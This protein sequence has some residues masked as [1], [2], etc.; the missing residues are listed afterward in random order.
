MQS[1]ASSLPI[2][3]LYLHELSFHLGDVLHQQSNLVVRGGV[4]EI[5][6]FL[7]VVLAAFDLSLSGGNS[8]TLF[9][10]HLYLFFLQSDLMLQSFFKQFDFLIGANPKFL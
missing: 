5:S 6:F 8:R 4:S 7:L 2:Q 3:L 10:Q 9:L 1:L